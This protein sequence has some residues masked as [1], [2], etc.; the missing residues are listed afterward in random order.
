MGDAIVRRQTCSSQVMR[1]LTFFLLGVLLCAAAVDPLLNEAD[2][3]EVVEMRPPPVP[4]QYQTP[5]HS[6]GEDW[7]HQTLRESELSWGHKDNR[8]VKD[9]EHRVH[10]IKVE[11][12]KV[13]KS[14]R[15]A[16]RDALGDSAL[17]ADYSSK[18]TN[19]GMDKE[20][21][22]LKRQRQKKWRAEAIATMT[23]YAPAAFKVKDRNLNDS[24]QHF[25]TDVGVSEAKVKPIKVQKHVPSLAELRHAYD[26]TPAKKNRQSKKY[27]HK[28]K[29]ITSLSFG[30]LR[31]EY[32]KRLRL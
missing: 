28:H 5:D 2:E 8:K 1:T 18:I 16:F 30:D 27:T 29:T 14:N 32:V 26:N 7:V 25:M 4:S 21:K 9:L 10:E 19:E 31:K 24:I 15:E 17:N 3:D 13:R 11:T 6:K 12:Q 22:K 20:L 23:E